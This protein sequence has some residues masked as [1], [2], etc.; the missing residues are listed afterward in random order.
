MMKRTL[1]PVLLLWSLGLY[2]GP[3]AV[4]PAVNS[5][6][7]KA[8]QE[9]S[10]GKG[11]ISSTPAA[12]KTLPATMPVKEKKA[13]NK[14]HQK[15]GA[16]SAATKKTTNKPASASQAPVAARVIRSTLTSGIVK[17][18]PQDSVLSLGSNEKKIYYFTELRGMKGKTAIHRWQYEGKVMAEIRFKVKGERWRIWSSKNLVPGWTGA[19]KV[20][21]VGEDGKVLASNGFSYTRA[22]DKPASAPVGKPAPGK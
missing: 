7:G 12:K 21:V 4:K 8:A 5:M 15:S 14:T 17:R 13:G 10:P 20:S 11:K 6:P 3:A 18:E 9:D 2:A 22:V 1:L 16:Q 19:W